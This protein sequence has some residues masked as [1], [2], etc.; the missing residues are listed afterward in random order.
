MVA[1]AKQINTEFMAF[2]DLTTQFVIDNFH[3]K[4][5]KNNQP[6][7]D[8]LE[9]P[10]EVSDDARK[11][12]DYLREKLEDEGLFYNEEELK[13]KF[14]N[15]LISLVDYDNQPYNVF[16]ERLIK[17]E[18]AGKNI[19][20][21]LDFMLASGGYEPA[22][23]FFFLHEYKKEKGTADD[24]LGQLLGGMLVAQKLNNNDKPVYGCYLIGRL[25]HFVVLHN[26]EFSVTG[27]HLGTNK[28]IFE[29]YGMLLKMKTIIK[30][31]LLKAKN[32]S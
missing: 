31:Q 25:W 1:I 6:L 3:I 10:F 14:L 32:P 2:K 12:L 7:K 29:I 22:A 8:W 20:G 4:R 26:Q 9:S 19:A 18:V 30:N 28:D 23:P 21:R 24:P 11:K 16:L 5:V 15:P 17:A 27:G 13:W